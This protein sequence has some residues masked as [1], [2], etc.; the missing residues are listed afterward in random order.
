MKP[1]RKP[2]NFS[3]IR[4]AMRS[5]KAKIGSARPWAKGVVARVLEVRQHPRR[6]RSGVN[7]DRYVE[8]DGMLVNR[9]KIGM[10]EGFVAFDTAEENAHSAQFF[11]S[12]HFFERLRDGAQRQHCHEPQPPV[13]F[14]ASIAEP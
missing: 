1:V 14:C 6:A 13:R 11:R 10:I 2:G 4:F 9:M 7:A 3:G 12:L 5:R 8:L